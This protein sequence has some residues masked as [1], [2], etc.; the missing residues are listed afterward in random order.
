MPIVASIPQAVLA[1]SKP[2]TTAI[3]I[4][5]D[6]AESTPM[7]SIARPKGRRFP[8]NTAPD[9]LPL[10]MARSNSSVRAE[11]RAVPEPMSEVF[12]PIRL[13]LN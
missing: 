13:M 12:S 1:Y 4:A 7:T 6:S 2:R 11:F 3:T 8:P 10:G 5:Q 9:W